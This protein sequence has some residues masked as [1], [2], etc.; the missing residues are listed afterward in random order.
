MDGAR[1]ERGLPESEP[2]IDDENPLE[3]EDPKV[4]HRLIDAI[5]PASMLVLISRSLGED[6]GRHI[7]PEDV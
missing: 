1:G 3:S 7:T 6:L 4:W 5:G 2:L